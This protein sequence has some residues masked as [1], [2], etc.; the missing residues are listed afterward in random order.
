[1]SSLRQKWCH[2]SHLLLPI[3]GPFFFP[4]KLCN[5]LLTKLY[6][7]TWEDFILSGCPSFFSLISFFCLRFPVPSQSWPKHVSAFNHMLLGEESK[8]TNVT[9]GKGKHYSKNCMESFYC[10]H[11]EDNSFYMHKT[12]TS[13]WA[14]ARK[15]VIFDWIIVDVSGDLRGRNC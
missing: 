2:F 4:G 5:V 6:S 1:M 11:E 3:F 14:G 8:I 10:F 9:G 7:D 15:R 12:H 13:V